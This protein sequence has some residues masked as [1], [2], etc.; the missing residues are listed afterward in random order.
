MK[1]QIKYAELMSPRGEGFQGFWVMDEKNQP[2][3]D[4]PFQTR[5]AAAS[6]APLL[7]VHRH[8]DASQIETEVTVTF[9]GV[10]RETIIEEVLRLVD[11]CDCID[12]VEVRRG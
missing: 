3:H 4:K 1:T 6:A 7:I 10:Q 8:M 11:G 9:R 12:S 5:Q 2:I